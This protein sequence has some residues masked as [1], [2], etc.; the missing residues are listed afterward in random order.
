[1]SDQ[2]LAEPEHVRVARE[3]VEAAAEAVRRGEAALAAARDAHDDADGDVTVAEARHDSFAANPKKEDWEVVAAHVELRKAQRRLGRRVT[4]LRAAEAAADAAEQALGEAEDALEAARRCVVDEPPETDADEMQEAPALYFETVDEWVR[5]WLVPTWERRIAEN[6]SAEGRFKWVA[7]WWRHP[8]AVVRLEAL[9]RA[10]EHLR[11][12][13]T[14]G[15]SV[16]LRDHA[17]HH[18]PLLMSKYGPFRKSKD[19]NNDG[20]PL[21]YIAPPEGMFSTGTDPSFTAAE[22]Q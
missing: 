1:M 14:T 12:D 7:E 13:P 16:W 5:C 19:E 3:R 11:L 18:L 17:D 6:A 10:W 15:M 21:P 2:Q 22:P 9:W 8:E 4:A 20:E